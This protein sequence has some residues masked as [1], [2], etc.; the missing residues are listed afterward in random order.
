MMKKKTEDFGEFLEHSSLV[1]WLVHICICCTWAHGPFTHMNTQSQP[2]SDLCNLCLC[3][4]IHILPSQIILLYYLSWI[5][6]CTK[7][8][9]RSQGDRGIFGLANIDVTPHGCCQLDEI[10]GSGKN[11]MEGQEDHCIFF[12]ERVGE[13]R[14]V[15]LIDRKIGPSY[16]AE[17]TAQVSFLLQ[18]RL[19]KGKYPEVNWT[20]IV[21]CPVNTTTTTKL[22]YC[23]CQSI[24]VRHL[25]CR[26]QPNINWLC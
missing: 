7:M 10:E 3:H 2:N 12:L 22:H 26:L 19:I 14:V 11:K 17:S 4:Q 23:C 8:A 25:I 18:T 1:W 13:L 21:W 6:T 20:G 15:V 9:L 5:N 24:L 16:N